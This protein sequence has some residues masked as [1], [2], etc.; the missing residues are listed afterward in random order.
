M[1]RLRTTSALHRL[2]S[3]KVALRHVTLLVGKCDTDRDG[4]RQYSSDSQAEQQTDGRQLLEG[5]QGLLGNSNHQHAE[6]SQANRAKSNW[7]PQDIRD[8]LHTAIRLR[9]GR[10]S[11]VLPEQLLSTFV[12]VYQKTMSADDRLKLFQLLCQ[13]FGA[14]GNSCRPSCCPAHTDV[15]AKVCRKV[16]M[17]ALRVMQSQMWTEP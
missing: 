16:T 17:D 5:W 12:Q 2:G 3:C 15:M 14:Q 8:L 7:K 11:G 10:V 6:S 4:S 9:H 1:H 13:D